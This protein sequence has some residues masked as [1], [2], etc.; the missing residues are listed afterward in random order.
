MTVRELFYA[1][2]DLQ[3]DDVVTITDGIK[4]LY[5]GTFGCVIKT[6]YAEY[7]VLVFDR[8]TMCIEVL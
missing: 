8:E 1:A 5:N 4:E 3:D 7:T 6:V 2:N